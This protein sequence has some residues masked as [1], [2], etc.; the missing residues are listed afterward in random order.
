MEIKKVGVIGC[1]LMGGGIAQVCAQSG[2]P[3]I[4]SEVNQQLL[5][6][7]L[8]AINAFLSKSVE[9]GKIT[10][11]DKAATLGRLKGTVS[12]EDFKDCDIVIEVVVENMDLKRKIFADLDRICPKHA[13]LASNT[14]CLSILDMAMATQRPTKV[15]GMHF[16][17]PVPTMK[18]L[19]IVETLIND[20]ETLSTAKAFGQSLGKTLIT[21]KDAPGFIV[22]RLLIPYIL[23]CIRVLESGFATKEDIDQG[24]VLGL[25]HPM[26]PFALAD[27]VGLDTLYFIANAMYDEFKDP[28]YVAPS[29]LK[30]MITAG[31][32]G[33]K[34]GKGF[35]DYNK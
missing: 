33:R 27:F 21:C 20:E 18:L 13:I 26:G 35:Y 1:G 31:H 25:N 23:D 11:D 22:N 8:A 14:S 6:K 7:G 28:K 17:N 5:D 10:A 16:F 2:Y 32:F 15:L 29:L 4:V 24:I 12:I 3:T 34:T 30:K 9:K 19:E